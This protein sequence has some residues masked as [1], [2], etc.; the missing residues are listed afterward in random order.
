MRGKKEEED[1]EDRRGFVTNTRLLGNG[2]YE[3]KSGSFSDSNL[4]NLNG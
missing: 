3:T 4:S 2:D 1:Y